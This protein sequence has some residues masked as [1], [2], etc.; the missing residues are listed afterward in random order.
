MFYIKLCVF[1]EYDYIPGSGLCVF[2]L[3]RG[4]SLSGLN[5]HTYF[6]NSQLGFLFCVYYYLDEEHVTKSN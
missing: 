1:I 4:R 2:S 5:T 3:I 6:T